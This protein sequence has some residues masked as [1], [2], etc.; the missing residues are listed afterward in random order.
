MRSI[1]QWCIQ[2]I[3]SHGAVGTLC[4]D[5][6]TQTCP[7]SF[8]PSSAAPNVLKVP[9][10]IA[11]ATAV[12]SGSQANMPMVRVTVCDPLIRFTVGMKPASQLGNAC[13]SLDFQ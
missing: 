7:E 8:I 12:V 11:A 9:F 1:S 6:P 3:G 10:D 4:I 5:P 2:K 13:S